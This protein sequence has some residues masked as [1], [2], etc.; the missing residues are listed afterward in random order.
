M[1]SI[2]IPA[3]NEEENIE[4]LIESIQNNEFEDFEIIVVDGDSEDRTRE[5]AREYGADVIEGLGK[6]L[7]AAQN[8]GWRNAS[9]EIVWFIDADCEL[10]SDSLR[11]AAEF[12]EENPDKA[13]G[14]LE[15]RHKPEGIIE[16][17]ISVENRANTGRGKIFGAI[18]SIGKKVGAIS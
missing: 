17:A 16:K 5:I 14:G 3:R 11:Q 1:I 4:R 12:F 15:V 13:I 8:L 2:V 9:G 18:R 10:E 7:A 6:G